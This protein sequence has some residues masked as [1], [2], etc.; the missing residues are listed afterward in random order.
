MGPRTTAGASGPQHAF[1]QRKTALSKH[2]QARFGDGPN[3]WG[4]PRG[5]GR[6]LASRVERFGLMLK[7][8]SN[9]SVFFL[10]FFF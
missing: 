2:V 6:Y 10:F 3:D 4:T 1:I 8:K 9:C 7:M 5:P